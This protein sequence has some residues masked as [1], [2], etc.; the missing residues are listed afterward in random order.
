MNPEPTISPD[1]E[2]SLD[3]VLAAI[4]RQAD[5]GQAPDPVHWQAQYPQFARELAE[6]FA[7]QQQVERWTAPLRA[8]ATPAAETLPVAP[9]APTS[10]GVR[11][12]GDYELLQELGQGGMGV[13]YR[14]RQK[15]L[16][17][18]LALKMVRAGQFATEADRLRFRHEAEVVAGLDHPHIVSIYEVGEAEEQQFFSMKLIEGGSLADRIVSNPG[19]AASKEAQRQ[20]AELIVQVARAVHHA[21][22][23]GILHRDLK[24]GNILLDSSGAA[25]VTDFG[26]AKRLQEL[27]PKEVPRGTQAAMPALT[28]SGAIVGTPGYMAPEQAAGQKGLSTAVDTYSLGAILYELLTGRPPFQGPTPLDILLQVLDREPEPLHRLNPQLDR[29]LETICLKCLEK[30]PEQRYPSAE[31]LARDL[32]RWLAGEPVQARRAAPWERLLKWSK[33]RPAAA[34]LVGVSAAAVLALLILSGSLWQNAELRAAAVQSLDEAETKIRQADDEIKVKRT[35]IKVKDQEIQIKKGELDK[36]RRSVQEEKRKADKVR[37]LAQGI[38]FDADMQFAHAAWHAE[39]L[40]RMVRLLEDYQPRKGAKDL[41][42]FE[43]HYLWQLCHGERRSWVA[44]APRPDK[45]KPADELP[46]ILALSPDGKVLASTSLDRRSSCG[47]RL[48]AN[49]CARCR[50]RKERFL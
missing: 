22:Q 48:P 21:H 39:D 42:G 30:G 4:L 10:A 34:S 8:A 41:R 32:E 38:R 35:E 7:A 20:A 27:N 1:V 23:H 36:L 29:D 49:C 33:R 15:S 28:Q 44:H 13:V 50:D 25:H 26:L 6:F 31:A 18:Q 16:N 40:P 46:V 2:I 47:T 19:P 14:A 17:R 45:D 5:D 24:P 3:V 12:F 37:D 9:A 11:S 43:W